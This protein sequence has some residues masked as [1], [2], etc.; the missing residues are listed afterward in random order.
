M[1]IL[2]RVFIGDVKGIDEKEGTLTAMVSTGARDRMDESLDPMGADIKNYLKNPVVLWAHDYTQPPIGKALWTKRTQDGVISKVKFANTEFAQEIF[3]LYK[4]GFLKAFSV[5]FVPKKW[6]DG[7][8][9]KKPRRKFTSWEML[10][11]SAVPV[12]ANPEALSLAISK[13]ILKTDS[14]IDAMETELND[15]EIEEKKD[16]A[17]SAEPTPDVVDDIEIKLYEDKVAELE[18]QVKEL[19]RENYDLRF[20]LYESLDKQP[21][22]KSSPEMTTDEVAKITAEAVRGVIRKHQGKLN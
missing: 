9:D 21:K 17:E 20:R 18:K 8:G 22:Q 2:K 14:I 7:D 11:F 4:D 13:G 15:P 19:K 10:E 16:C 1:E 3:Q 5:G 12:P 6:E